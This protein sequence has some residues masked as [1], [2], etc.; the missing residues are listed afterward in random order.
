[1]WPSIKYYSSSRVVLFSQTENTE[2]DC[3]ILALCPSPPPLKAWV[4]R[5]LILCNI[6]RNDSRVTNHTYMQVMWFTCDMH[7]SP[8]LTEYSACLGTCRYVL[9]AS[10]ILQQSLVKL[11][12]RQ[13]NVLL[14]EG[15]ESWWLPGGKWPVVES[16]GIS[17]QGYQ[18]LI[19]GHCSFLS[20]ICLEAFCSSSFCTHHILQQMIKTGILAWTANNRVTPLH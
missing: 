3:I 19:S 11:K 7:G 20:L 4:Y 13:W 15:C 10:E 12:W 5:R 18:V 17:S 2:N 9:R 16:T 8:I 6:V 1:M 14:T